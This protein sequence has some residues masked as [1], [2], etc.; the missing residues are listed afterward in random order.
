MKKYLGPHARE[1]KKLESASRKIG[2]IRARTAL[3][4]AR[5]A[6]YRAIKELFLLKEPTCQ[7]CRFFR[8][9]NAN[10]LWSDDV[11]H[12]RGREGLLLFDV[13]FFKAV[14]IP[15]HSKIHDNPEL[16]RKFGLLCEKGDWNRLPSK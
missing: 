3:H 1:K 12:T 5:M 6:V 14:C 2:G 9:Q 8:G 11:H 16:S 7:A 10:P 15:C 13:R 4:D